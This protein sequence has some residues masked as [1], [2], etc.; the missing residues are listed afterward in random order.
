MTHKSNIQS[1]VNLEGIFLVFQTVIKV[2]AAN[3]QRFLPTQYK[4]LKNFLTFYTKFVVIDILQTRTFILF[5][6]FRAH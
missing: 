2:Y 5:S 1:K 4:L 3:H 6:R